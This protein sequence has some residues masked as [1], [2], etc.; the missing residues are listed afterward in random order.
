MIQGAFFDEA[1]EQS[2][3][4]HEVPLARAADPVT[5]K[6]AAASMVEGAEHHRALILEALAFPSKPLTYW[7]IAERA[8]LEPVAVARR[9]ASMIR[10]GLIIR[11]DGKDGRPKA[12]RESPS[13]RPA[14]LH[15][16]A[17]GS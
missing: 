17:G 14:F 9:L 1:P 16:R 2:G 11:L 12:M 15:T 6:V 7:E 13:G 8:G 4:R 3:P 5:S 10:E